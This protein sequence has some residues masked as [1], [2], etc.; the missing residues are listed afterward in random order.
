MLLAPKSYG[1]AEGGIFVWLIL[2]WKERSFWSI[3]QNKQIVRRLLFK[4]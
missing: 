3:A 4:E 2:L 1:T